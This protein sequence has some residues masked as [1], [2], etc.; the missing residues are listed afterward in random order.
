MLTQQVNHD[1]T[2]TSVEAIFKTMKGVDLHRF[3]KMKKVYSF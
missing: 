2:A 1:Q 3:S